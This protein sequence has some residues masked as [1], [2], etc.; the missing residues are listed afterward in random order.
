MKWKRL[1]AIRERASRRAHA[2]FAVMVAFSSRHQFGRLPA[3]MCQK[4]R[5]ILIPKKSRR[6]SILTC[7]YGV[8]ESTPVIRACWKSNRVSEKQSSARS[9]TAGEKENC[10]VAV[11]LGYCRPSLR[12]HRISSSAMSMQTI[13]KCRGKMIYQKFRHQFALTK[14][15][16][17]IPYTCSTVRTSLAS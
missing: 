8:S 13:G 10:R 6:I 4:D 3:V 2:S 1:I 7:I 16:A 12:F 14:K 11:R 17:S 9:I 15:F 5:C